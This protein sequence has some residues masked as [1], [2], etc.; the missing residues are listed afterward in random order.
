MNTM[1]LLGSFLIA[2]IHAKT[3]N[4]NNIKNYNASED[5]TRFRIDERKILLIDTLMHKGEVVV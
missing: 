5:N 1:S 2:R 4:Y 3:S